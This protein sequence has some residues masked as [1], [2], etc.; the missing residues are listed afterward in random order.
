MKLKIEV[1]AD[2]PQI[3]KLVE[4]LAQFD[5]TLVET[6]KDEVFDTS[7]LNRDVLDV[8]DRLSWE[9]FHL[10]NFIYS[11]GTLV[12]DWLEG[13]NWYICTLNQVQEE[14]ELAERNVRS[15]VNGIKKSCD[16]QKIQPFVIPYNINSERKYCVD[17]SVESELLY[18]LNKW[19]KTYR[20][21]LKE[22]NLASLNLRSTELT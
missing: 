19:E 12:E 15:R 17:K 16:R 20:D 2:E 14:L 5:I 22:S 1:E 18:C 10:V 8:F 9:S 6:N 3:H 13:K 4:L 7:E 21:W 11:K